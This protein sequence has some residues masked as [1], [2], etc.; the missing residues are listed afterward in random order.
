[1]GG[2]PY[3]VFTK[4]YD[5]VVWPIFSYGAAIW[6]SKSFSYINAVQNRAMRFFLGT[7][8]YT[9]MASIFGEMTWKHPLVK[10][11]KC[12][13]AQWIR[14]VNMESV[15]LNKHIFRCGNDTSSRACKIWIYT[16]KDQFNELGLSQFCDISNP[17]LKSFPNSILD[18]M[19]EK[20]EADWS[21]MLNTVSSRRGNGAN[22]LRTYKLFKTE[23]QV[24]EYCEQL[25][26]LKHRS[27]FAKFR[28]GVAPIKIE[29]GHYENLVVEERICPF[30]SNIEDE[31]HVILDCS[32]YKDLRITLLDN[33]SDMYPGF[34]DLTNSEKFKILFSERRLIRFLCEKLF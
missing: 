21:S 8:K 33:A 16:A 24:E 14:L 2:M 28:C 7:G 23:F 32:V 11:W 30:C 19:M 26:P 12:I 9:P 3:D 18:K 4:L 15:R 29:T 25:L 5:S 31:M 27:A 34:K 6:G 13:S 1:M 17:I 20:F 22:K 10:Q